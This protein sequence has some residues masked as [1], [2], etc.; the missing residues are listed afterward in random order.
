MDA[1]ALDAVLAEYGLSASASERLES[2]DNDVFKIH[3]PEGDRFV[4]RVHHG[5]DPLAEA[6]AHAW[7]EHAWLAHI[8]AS[9]DLVVPRPLRTRSGEPSGTARIG[10]RERVFMLFAWIEGEPGDAALDRAA[11]ER[12]G[13]AIA[14][15]HASSRDVPLAEEAC[16]VHWGERTFF[17]RDS[18][19]GSGQALGFGA[20]RIR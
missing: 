5:F 4:L 16:R 9:T 20:G 11:A 3:T 8:R 19:L 18:W 13:R 1:P 10:D 12:M 7:T 6:R 2:A 15:L 14:R 17:G